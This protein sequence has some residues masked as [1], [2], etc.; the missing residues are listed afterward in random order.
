MYLRVALTLNN[1]KQ[2][3]IG[4]YLCLYRLVVNVHFKSHFVHPSG[5]P[6]VPH[7]LRCQGFAVDNYS[8]TLGRLEAGVLSAFA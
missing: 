5:K 1:R 2:N 7:L 3:G 4:F 6:M 8:F